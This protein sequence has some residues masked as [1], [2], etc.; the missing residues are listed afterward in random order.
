MK[1][2]FLSSI[3]I[4]C[5]AGTVAMLGLHS[6]WANEARPQYDLGVLQNP[7][8]QAVL[9]GKEKV[10][11]RPGVYRGRVDG[12]VFITIKDANSLEVDAGGVTMICEKLTRAIEI[13]NCQNIQIRGLTVDYDPLPFTQGTI[14]EVDPAGKWVDVKIRD[15]YPL[16]AYSR[17]D[18]VDAKT[19]HRKHG[20][21]FLWGTK[22]E[23]R[24]NG[25]VRVTRE[26]GFERCAARGDL[27]SLSTG[28][29][30]GGISHGVEIRDSEKVSLKD[31]TLHAAPGYGI[32]NGGGH[33]DHHY[34]NVRVVQGPKP[35][36]ATEDRLL[37][38][39]W[40]AIQF[41]NLRKGPTMENCLVT[42]AGDD[43]W[44]L[45]SRDYLVLAAKGKDVWLVSRVPV[46]A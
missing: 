3:Q 16:E 19:R 14:V 6:S 20:M 26:N 8:A 36:G 11:L 30:A 39:S 4:V 7:I 37:S 17:I 31:F 23:L 28:P 15:G 44:S 5:Y 12:N 2:V 43:S 21:P 42:A 9:S 41:N 38:S 1:D 22:A 45:S 33:G 27:A 35:K 46:T 34:D 32:I 13:H 25:I 18:I 29:E 24:D 10:V 40:D